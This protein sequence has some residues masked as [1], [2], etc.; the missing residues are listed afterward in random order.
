MNMSLRHHEASVLGKKKN[1]AG[2]IVFSCAFFKKRIGE[3]LGGNEKSTPL[4]IKP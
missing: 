4:K 1:G 2:V 3:F